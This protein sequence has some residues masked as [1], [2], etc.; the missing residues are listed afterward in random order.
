MYCDVMQWTSIRRRILREGV[1]IRQVARE[2]G[3]HRSTVRRMLDHPRPKPYGPRNRRYLKPGPH[4]A[5]IQRMLRE[6]LLCRL[7]PNFR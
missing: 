1:S 4:T 7:Q 5:S 6:T 3:L 2:T